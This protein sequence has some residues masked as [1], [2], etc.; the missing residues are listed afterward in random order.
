[1]TSHNSIHK[2]SL[3]GWAVFKRLYCRPV[4]RMRCSGSCVI[5]AGMGPW[6]SAP[7]LPRHLPREG[8]LGG[9]QPKQGSLWPPGSLVPLLSCA[10][11]ADLLTASSYRADLFAAS[12]LVTTQGLG[13]PEVPGGREVP[14]ESS[15]VAQWVKD[16]PL[17]LLWLRSL[18]W[19]EFNPWPRNFR[20]P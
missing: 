12:A 13:G 7:F 11:R 20:M 2:P 9:R 14:W 19:R 4:R 15:L 8:G 18:L 6:E 10:D 3:K 16:R 5:H 1:M 17:S